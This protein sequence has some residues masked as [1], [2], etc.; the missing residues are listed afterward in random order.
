MTKFEF[1]NEFDTITGH[2]I[3][4]KISQKYQGDNELLP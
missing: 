3:T 2:E 4:L 1:F